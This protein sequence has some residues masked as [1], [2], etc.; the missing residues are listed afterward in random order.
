MTVRPLYAGALQ[1][2][3][4]GA[5]LKGGFEFAVIHP[6]YDAQGRRRTGWTQVVHEDVP[7]WEW[8]V[9]APVKVAL[10]QFDK[11]W[12][13]CGR[14]EVMAKALQQCKDARRACFQDGKAGESP[15]PSI[16]RDGRGAGK[17]YVT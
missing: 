17:T 15:A 8:K 14:P 11:A 6:G 7:I 10:I 2:N 3:E 9:Q 5:F 4:V 12:E 1:A 13:A 16:T